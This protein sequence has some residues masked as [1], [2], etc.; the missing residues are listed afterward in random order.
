MSPAAAVPKFKL[1]TAKMGVHVEKADNTATSGRK[2][3]KEFMGG[4]TAEVVNSPRFSA[5]SR[6]SRKSAG[7]QVKSPRP[8]VSPRLS[9]APSKEQAVE[10]GS[11]FGF[12]GGGQSEVSASEEEKRQRDIEEKR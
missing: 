1:P 2:S 7:E 6:L 3:A 9:A 4:S 11:W 8:S 5:S 10:E 12:L